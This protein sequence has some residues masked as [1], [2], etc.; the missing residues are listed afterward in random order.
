[1]VIPPT[2][3]TLSL[4]PS[5]GNGVV[6]ASL[7]GTAGQTYVIEASADLIHWQALSTNIADAAGIVSL[8]DSNAM[9]FPSR[10]YRAYSP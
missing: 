10:F 2:P 7:S 9:A 6:T 1:M 8:V 5:F 3:S 4:A